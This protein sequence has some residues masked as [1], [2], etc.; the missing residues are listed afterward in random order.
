MNDSNSSRVQGLDTLRAAAILLVMLFHLT[1]TLPAWMQQVSSYG[2]MGVDL[3]FVLS[4]YL[5][6]TQLLRPYAIGMQPS[7]LSFYRRRLYRV[8][9]AYV[10]VLLLYLLVPMWREAPT[11]SPAWQ[12]LTFTENLFVDYSKNQAFSHVWSL[13]VEEHF[14]LFMPLLVALLMRRPRLWKAVAA[15]TSFV[16]LGVLLRTLVLHGT[17]RVLTPEAENYGLKYVET[18]YYPTWNRL[19]GL[20]AGVALAAIRQFSP[21]W[22]A[23]AMARGHALTL[24]DWVWSL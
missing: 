24:A 14:Y 3:F 22:W 10:A 19:D 12:F 13:C 1:G 2:W 7:W 4:G 16:L 6:G 8:L 5:I 21:G 11:M 20:I 17:L 15:V 18:L 9:P 23:V